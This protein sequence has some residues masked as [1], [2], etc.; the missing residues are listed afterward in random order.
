MCVLAESPMYYDCNRYISAC[1]A[2]ILKLFS[3]TIL[4]GM[5]HFN[6]THAKN[7]R[8]QHWQL[9]KKDEMGLKLES[10][11]ANSVGKAASIWKL[12]ELTFELTTR[13]ESEAEAK[14]GDERTS[15]EMIHH[16]LTMT[17]EK[18]SKPT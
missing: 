12:C 6:G 3:N 4:V 7:I 15:D 1:K 14:Q 11:H 8:L 13:N 17:L 18:M 5:H 16:H 10:T 2:T 9:P